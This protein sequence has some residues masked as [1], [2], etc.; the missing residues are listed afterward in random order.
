MKGVKGP[1]QIHLHGDRAFVGR[2]QEM[3]QLRMA[4]EEAA[5]GRPNQAMLVVEPG[6]GKS[7]ISQELTNYA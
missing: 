5:T 1:C 6:I 3:E 2:L 7:R 4:Q